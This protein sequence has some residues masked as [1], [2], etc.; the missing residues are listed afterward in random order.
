MIAA[1][2]ALGWEGPF[3][4][5]KHLYMTKGE[6][7]QTIPNPHGDIGVGLISS[8]LKQAGISKEEWAAV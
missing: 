8:V 6:K 3:S 4:G 5:G 1:F 2:K 7:T